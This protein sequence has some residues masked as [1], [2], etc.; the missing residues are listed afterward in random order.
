M[1]KGVIRHQEDARAVALGRVEAEAGVQAEILGNAGDTC[2][3]FYSVTRGTPVCNRIQWFIMAA[4]E[5]ACRP[6]E[7][8]TEAAF[9]PIQEALECITYTQDRS[10][11]A[12]TW[13]KYRNLDKIL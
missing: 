8:F 7:P 13:E 1:P 10:L 12:I 6:A 11:A 3:E 4:K 9:F 2:Y 5:E